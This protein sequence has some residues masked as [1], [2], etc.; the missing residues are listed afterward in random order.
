[1][2]FL[3][4]FLR[5]GTRVASVAPSSGPMAREMC[6]Y[7]DPSQPQVIV[8]LGAG[9]GAITKQI[10]KQ[11]HPNTRVIAIEMDS[12]FLKRLQKAVNPTEI[13][14][15][16]GDVR[17]VENFLTQRGID[18][19]DLVISG[20]ALP[21]LPTSV[22]DSINHLMRTR[23]AGAMYSQ[24]TEIPWQLYGKYYKGM[25]D[26]VDY[27]RVPINFPPGGVYHCRHTDTVVTQ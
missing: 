9:T 26:K 4:K 27:R 5:H 3:R 2:I 7:V 15:C 22:A 23:A 10:A 16:H 11:K 8:E 19:V 14:I 25:F 18:R 20:L 6:R 12:D 13:D 17:E 21:S 24:L 1:M